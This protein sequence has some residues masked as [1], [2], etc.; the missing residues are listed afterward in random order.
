MYFEKPVGTHTVASISILNYSFDDLSI[1]PQNNFCCVC[2]LIN[3]FVLR[4]GTINLV[5][6]LDLSSSVRVSNCRS[7]T[8]NLVDRFLKN[9][10]FND[11]IV[12]NVGPLFLPF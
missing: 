7:G 3:F 10:I 12:Y 8:C 11:S 9:M 1:V 4:A 2:V 6:E 5:S